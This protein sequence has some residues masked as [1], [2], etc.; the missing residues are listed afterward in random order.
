MTAALLN[1][2]HQRNGRQ[3]AIGRML[4]CIKFS[5]YKYI[6]GSN[7]RN[8]IKN[9]LDVNKGAMAI[10]AKGQ[11]GNIYRAISRWATKIEAIK[12]TNG[13]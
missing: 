6:A 2:T 8:I 3:S 7:I 12:N 13:K 10:A 4:Y 9:F 5:A 1:Y 11:I